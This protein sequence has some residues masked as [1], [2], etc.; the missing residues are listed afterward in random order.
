MT[1]EVT[2]S[3]RPL[4]NPPG[5]SLVSAS[6]NRITTGLW[7]ADATPADPRIP[8]ERVVEEVPQLHVGDGHRIRKV[9][10]ERNRPHVRGSV[11][12]EITIDQIGAGSGEL[13]GTGDPYRVQPDNDGSTVVTGSTCSVVV[14]CRLPPG[15]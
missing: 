7:P 8:T 13:R 6:S 9:D 11:R 5:S 3:H 14:V 4:P 2:P 1:S 12:G 10:R 15:V